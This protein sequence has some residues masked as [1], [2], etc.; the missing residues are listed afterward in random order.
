M[1]L[2]TDLAKQGAH[3]GACK[4]GNM[5]CHVYEVFALVV[6]R[7]GRNLSMQGRSVTGQIQV[8]RHREEMHCQ[9]LSVHTEPQ[10]TAP[11]QDAT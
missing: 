6:N 2:E 1:Q 3:S 10:Q 4:Q 8:S 5:H 11:W 7:G 9:Q